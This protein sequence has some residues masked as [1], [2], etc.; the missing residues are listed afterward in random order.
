MF[1]RD[2][3]RPSPPIFDQGRNGTLLPN[4][5]LPWRGSE[6]C[7]RERMSPRLI[8]LAAVAIAFASCARSLPTYEKPIARTQFQRIRTT[9]YTHSEGDHV[10][11]GA[12]TC[13]GTRLRYD[14]VH[15]AACDWSRW[16]LG[17]T[18][19]ILDTG[20]ICKV[21]DIG[22]ALSGRNTIDLYKPS[23]GDMNAWGT[24]TVNIEILNWGDDRASLAVL[25]KRSKYR[26]V[27]RMVNDLEKVIASNR[28]SPPPVTIAASAEVPGSGPAPSQA[29]QAHA[30]G[31]LRVR[32]DVGGPE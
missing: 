10:R 3:I 13:I 17:T 23:R 5:T 31:G 12:Q 28:H 24:R 18:F 6:M 30:E 27:Q 29:F 15:S 11:Y 1:F 22:W 19:R 14:A 25:R 16:P 7:Y 26:H 8:L 21:D 2:L 32:K 9:A 20:E 4:G